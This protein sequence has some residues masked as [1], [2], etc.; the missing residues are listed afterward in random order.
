MLKQCLL[1]FTSSAATTEEAM[2]SSSSSYEMAEPPARMAEL[3]L[4]SSC[5]GKLAKPLVLIVQIRES[6]KGR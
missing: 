3:P 5:A 2:Y 1:A 6:M 4:E